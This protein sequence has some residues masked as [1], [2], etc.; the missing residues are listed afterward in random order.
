YNAD[1]EK[2]DKLTSMDDD[3]VPKDQKDAYRK[4]FDQVYK[5]FES[6]L[7]QIG[8]VASA[9][10][11][12]TSDSSSSNSSGVVPSSTSD[13]SSSSSDVTDA[14]KIG[15]QI[16]TIKGE[17]GAHAQSFSVDTEGDTI[18]G[19]SAGVGTG[20]SASGDTKP[21]YGF[22]DIYAGGE[23]DV[24]FVQGDGSDDPGVG[25]ILLGRYHMRASL[26]NFG[27]AAEVKDEGG[28][29]VAGGNLNPNG[30]ATGAFAIGGGF[31]ISGNVGDRVGLNIG[32]NF[33]V[34]KFL[35]PN[36]AVTCGGTEWDPGIVG[37]SGDLFMGLEYYP[38]S[39]LSLG[40]GAALGF[41]HTES[42][43]CVVDPSTI[44]TDN[45][46]GASLVDTSADSFSATGRT[47]IGVHF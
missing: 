31:R 26:P 44:T 42:Q 1:K 6:D 11:P 23:I 29:T 22:G 41:G 9:S 36:T 12:L 43:W 4:E 39:F 45:P 28:S 3:V 19:G 38:L 46:N 15:A 37:G 35:N 10:A 30:D 7:A 20:D 33:F 24:N 14:P 8:A 34:S 21:T 47:Q 16:F 18:S 32:I 25:V 17:F 5:P 13:T 27:S 2:L 40:V